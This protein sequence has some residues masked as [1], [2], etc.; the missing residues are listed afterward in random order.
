MA[1]PSD[2]PVPAPAT[3]PPTPGMVPPPP[4][5]PSRPRRSLAWVAV[6]VAVV[7]VVASI[8]ALYAAGVGPFSRTSAPSGPLTFSQARNVADQSAS[9][10]G[11]GGWSLIAASS[12][13]TPSSVALPLSELQANLSS[14]LSTCP[15]DWI[16]TASS[17][18]I[19]GFAGSATSGQSPAWALIYKNASGGALA[20]GVINGAAQLE[21]SIAGG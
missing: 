3:A 6:V 14:T 2:A 5:P 8:G 15:V 20:V 18:T 4:P 12:I 10:Y 11:G 7:V 13:D 9:G 16:N 1:Q 17:V 21:A 19:P